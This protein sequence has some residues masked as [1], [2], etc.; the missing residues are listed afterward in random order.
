MGTRASLYSTRL[1]VPSP[2]TA[3][4]MPCRWA[5]ERVLRTMR[6]YGDVHV[7]GQRDRRRRGGV[8]LPGRNK[9]GPRA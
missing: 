7:R 4:I 1:R 9:R 8:R 3:V 6:G 5:A 2:M